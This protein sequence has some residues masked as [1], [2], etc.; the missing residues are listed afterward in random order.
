MSKGQVSALNLNE[1]TTTNARA[2][3]L[4]RAFVVV[5]GCWRRLRLLLFAAVGLAFAVEVH[6][7]V[8]SIVSFALFRNTS[9]LYP[10]TPFFHLG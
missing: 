4:V 1:Q 5:C 7:A 10:S 9:S 8:P 3:F 6:E 2:R